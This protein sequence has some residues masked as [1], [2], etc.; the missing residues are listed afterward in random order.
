MAAFYPLGRLGTELCQLPF[1]GLDMLVKHSPDGDPWLRGETLEVIIK[2]MAL[3]SGREYAD[4]KKEVTI[5]LKAKHEK[6]ESL[7]NANNQS[8]LWRECGGFGGGIACD[9]LEK[10]YD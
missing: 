7:K 9:V 2:R 4:V 8:V 6:E 10:M 5:T 1:Y 3:L